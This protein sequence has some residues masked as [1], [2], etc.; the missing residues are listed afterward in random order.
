M[1][2]ELLDRFGE[3]PRSVL[4][5]LEIASVKAL[6]H[7]AYVTE[8]SEKADFIRFTLYEKAAINPAGIPGLVK[9]QCAR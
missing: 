5:L 2:E 3:P 9:D 8:V 7:S 4:N 6:A 1:L